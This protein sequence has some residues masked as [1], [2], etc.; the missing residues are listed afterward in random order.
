M[1]RAV[2]QKTT[3]NLTLLYNKQQMQSMS[4]LITLAPTPCHSFVS[5][6]LFLK[7]IFA[8]VFHGCNHHYGTC[9]E[10]FSH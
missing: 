9:F 8:D 5:L 1:Q 7:E 2:L 6:L 4:G 10:V 3:L